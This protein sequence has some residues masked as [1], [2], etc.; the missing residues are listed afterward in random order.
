MP[1]TLR[2]K[3]EKELIRLVSIGVL[4]SV[5]SCLL[6]GHRLII[7]HSLR[8]DILKELHIAHAGIVKMKA[9]TRSF[10]RWPEI[11]RDLENISKSCTLCL[12]GQDNP[13]K[14]VLHL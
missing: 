2:V 5:K 6:W 13:P 7:P 9:L 14:S 3:L 1:Y 12:Q 10:V 11:D 8:A 4:E